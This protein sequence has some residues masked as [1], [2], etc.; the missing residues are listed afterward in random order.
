MK[1][2]RS[3]FSLYTQAGNIFIR[4][5]S[6]SPPLKV[7]DLAALQRLAETEP[8]G[9]AQERT[10]APRWVA[11]MEQAEAAAQMPGCVPGTGGESA[12]M[13]LDSSLY[14]H[15]FHVP[16]RDP[17]PSLQRE[18]AAP[19]PADPGPAPV[20][21]R[22]QAECQPPAS[23]VAARH[24]EDEV[25]AAASAGG[26]HG[27]VSA[28]SARK[29]N[30]KSEP[31]MRKPS[32]KFKMRVSVSGRCRIITLSNK[33]DVI[34]TIQDLFTAGNAHPLEYYK[35]VDSLKIEYNLH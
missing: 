35:D 25:A 18:P 1:N 13:G 24:V 22:D 23:P 31:S 27:T 19:P 33:N 16:D 29:V 21:H 28:E 15:G 4:K 34:Q 12:A 10:Q 11:R 14:G 20:T 6:D 7:P 5:S 9:P 8:S 3:I 17:A 2:R 26:G 32:S 30:Q